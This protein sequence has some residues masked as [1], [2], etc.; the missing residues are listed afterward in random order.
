VK[1]PAIYNRNFAPTFPIFD[2]MFGTFYMP[3]GVLPAD[4]G[5]DG[6][7]GHFI[8]QLIYPFRIIAG[9]LGPARKARLPVAAA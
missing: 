8:G 1:D 7:P 5:V 6:V 4:Y 9:R 3:K 2:L